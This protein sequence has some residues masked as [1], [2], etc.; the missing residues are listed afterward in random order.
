M[1]D[2]CGNGPGYNNG[3][4]ISMATSASVTGPWKIQPLRIVDQWMSDLLDCTH[5][6]PTP[7]FLP[8]GTV[9][10]AFN[11]GFCHSDLETIGIASAPHWSG[12]YMLL[13][14]VRR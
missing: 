11:A 3:C 13:S 2:L 4:G 10:L 1:G 7:F 5:T 6:N 8:N 9:V 14:K 12:P